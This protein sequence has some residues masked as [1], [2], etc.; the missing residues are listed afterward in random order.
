MQREEFLKRV[1]NQ[2]EAD[3]QERVPFRPSFVTAD[4]PVRRDHVRDIRRKS[5]HGSGQ[6]FA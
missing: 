4:R 6:P 3:A 5:P 1:G 2:E